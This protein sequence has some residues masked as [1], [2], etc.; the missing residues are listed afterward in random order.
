MTRPDPAFIG[1]LDK[2]TDDLAQLRTRVRDVLRVIETVHDDN[3]DSEIADEV[4]GTVRD[5]ES[6]LETIVRHLRK[7]V[8]AVTDYWHGKACAES[9]E[10]ERARDAARWPYRSTF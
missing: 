6:E 1:T 10:R 8:D 2:I 9:E 5:A 3:P 7:Q 4:V